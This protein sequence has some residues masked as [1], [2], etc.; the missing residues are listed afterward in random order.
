MHVIGGYAM[1]VAEHILKMFRIYL[2]T[3]IDLIGSE[4]LSLPRYV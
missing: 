3:S 4:K 2:K 1:F